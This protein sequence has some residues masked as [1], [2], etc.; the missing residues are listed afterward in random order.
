MLSL[1]Q[2]ALVLSVVLQAVSASTFTIE[3]DTFVK[4]GKAFQI[5]S[6][7]IH[8]SRVP[9]AYWDDRLARMKA[10]G[11]NSIEVYAPWN[12][13]ETEEGHFNFEGNRDLVAFLKKAQQA[14]LLVLFRAGPYICGEWEFGGFPSYL[15]ARRPRLSLR[16]MDAQYMSAVERWWGKLLPLVKPLLVENGGPIAMVQVENEFGSFGDV[17]SNTRD[18]EYLKRLVELAREQLGENVVL[19]TTDGGSSSFFQRGTLKGGAVYSVGDHGPQSDEGNCAAMRDVNAPGKSPCMDSEFYTGWLSHW[20]EKM[21][22]T[23][24]ATV[25]QY[26]KGMVE[27]GASISFYMA[28]GGTNFGFW[29]GANGDGARNYLAHIT[30]YDYDSPISG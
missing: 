24:T 13:H 17:S 27:S 4:D 2:L 18:L 8:Y 14:G 15:L 25:A 6:G 16:T 11:L 1:L 28:H 12:W 20:S 19:Y 23:S 9:A 3:N 26:A 7:S 5:L 29:S 10:M 22:N 21:A 30:S